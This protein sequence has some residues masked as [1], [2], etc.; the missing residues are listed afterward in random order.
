MNSRHER[1]LWLLALLLMPLATFLITNYVRDHKDFLAKANEC[2]ATLSS[3]L[4]EKQDL[5]AEKELLRQENEALK[6][7]PLR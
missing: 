6:T 4:G 1:F 3:I 2:K 5:L 7:R